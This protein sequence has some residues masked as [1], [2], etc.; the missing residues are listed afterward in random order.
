MTS[1]QIRLCC[2]LSLHYALQQLQDLFHLFISAMFYIPNFMLLLLRRRKNRQREREI[3]R[4]KKTKITLKR[5][6]NDKKGASLHCVR[7]RT[8]WRTK[9]ASQ[10]KKEETKSGRLCC[11]TSHYRA[12]TSTHRHFINGIF[13]PEIKIV[14]FL[15]VLFLTDKNE[16]FNLSMRKI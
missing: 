15:C 10:I 11:L 13:F 14:S 8:S 12:T 3:E 6:S 16:A 5:K 2:S 9:C 1:D 4:E 7:M